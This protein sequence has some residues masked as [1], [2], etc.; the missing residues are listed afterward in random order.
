M[1]AHTG[2]S[3]PL[4]SSLVSWLVTDEQEKAVQVAK[5]RKTEL[6]AKFKKKKDDQ[7]KSQKVGAVRIETSPKF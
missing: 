3:P 6:E 7:E 2:K 1:S 4:I 5:K